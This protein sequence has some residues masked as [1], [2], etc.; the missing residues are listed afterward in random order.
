MS[1]FIGVINVITITTTAV[2]IVKLVKPSFVFCRQLYFD[3][4]N[5]IEGDLQDIFPMTP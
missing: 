1:S 5:M 2:A 4:T 3:Q